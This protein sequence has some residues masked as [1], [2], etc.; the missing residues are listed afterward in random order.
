VPTQA[1]F[2]AAADALDALA[3]DVPEVL[4]P[5]DALVTQA[6]LDGGL[7]TRQ[8]TSA[9]RTS[10][11]GLTVVAQ[12]CRDA[13][14]ESRWRGEVCALHWQHIAV[15]DAALADYQRAART[16]LA[17]YEEHRASSTTPD[18]GPPPRAP[19]AAPTKPFTWVD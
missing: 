4:P 3:H 12:A 7:L 19:G 2:L 6:V 5:V 17:R 8:V 10:T 15:W 11:S 13:A 9:L 16:W 1:T 14:A 18:P